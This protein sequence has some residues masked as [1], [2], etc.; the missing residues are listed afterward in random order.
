MLN[1]FWSHQLLFSYARCHNRHPIFSS[2][3]KHSKQ[4]Y[5]RIIFFSAWQMEY[6]EAPFN[7][8]VRRCCPNWRA[9]SETTF[10]HKGCSILGSSHPSHICSKQI[11]NSKSALQWLIRQDNGTRVIQFRVRILRWRP[12]FMYYK[13]SLSVIAGRRN[14]WSPPWKS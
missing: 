6:K 8:K 14:L 4:I 13:P 12:L 10:P 11:K 2:R 3:P 7:Y 1:L 9:F 5:I